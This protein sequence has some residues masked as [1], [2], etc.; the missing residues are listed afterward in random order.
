MANLLNTIFNFDS[1]ESPDKLGA[2]PERLHVAALPERRYLWTTRILVIISAVSICVSIMLAFIC[3]VLVPQRSSIPQLITYD[4]KFNTLAFVES[5]KTTVEAAELLTEMMASEYVIMRHT[6]VN[7]ID[8]MNRRWGNYSKLYWYSSKEVYGPFNAETVKMLAMATSSGLTRDVEIKWVIPKAKGLWQVEFYTYD[9]K[10]EFTEPDV[11]IWRALMRVG[12]AKT[13]PFR[14]KED[15]ALNPTNF[16][17]ANYSL[18][19]L[20]NAK[21]S[22]HYMGAEITNTVAKPQNTQSD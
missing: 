20:G 16:T 14:N 12:F 7:D 4:S 6:I 19:Y 11:N 9:M 21:G 10:P 5:N 22:K 3:Y 13:L 8:E 1:G 18:S 17:V 15:V 2:Y